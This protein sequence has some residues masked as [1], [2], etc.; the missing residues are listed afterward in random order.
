MKAEVLNL[1]CQQNRKS[2]AG[3]CAYETVS[4]PELIVVVVVVDCV[5]VTGGGVIVLVMVV[6]SGV[7]A[8]VMLHG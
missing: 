1:R 6:V 8:V 2:R 4:V 5:T 7:G 3:P